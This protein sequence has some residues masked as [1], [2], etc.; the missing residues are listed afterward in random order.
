MKI[1]SSL[2]LICFLT[3]GVFAQQDATVFGRVTY[4]GEPVVEGRV[5]INSKSDASLRFETTTD[6]NGN[7]RFE[8]IPTGRYSILAKR[9]ID[10]ETGGKLEVGV[11][12]FDLNSG[13]KRSINIEMSITSAFR[14]KE[15][16]DVKIA[17]GISQPID[18]VSKTV[19]IIDSQ[20]IAN[21]NEFSFADALRT[22]PGLRVQQLGGFG[23]TA[24]IKTRGL[25]NQDTA[26]LIDGVRFRDA[27]SITG[28]A[29]AFLSDFVFTN[30]DR[31]EVLRGSGS[32]LYGTNAIG[33]V[34]DF[35]TERPRD[36][37]HG[38]FLGEGGNL[39]LKRILG[40]V[41]DGFDNFGFSLGVSRTVYSEG[42]DG[43]DDA[44][45]TNATGRIDFRPTDKTNISG[46]VYFS[47]AFVR[48]NS[49]PDTI[50]T[51]PATNATIIDAN[52]LSISELNRYADGTPVS[53][54]DAVNANFIPD[55][56]D[57][58]AI[59]K[60]SFF[61]GQIS[62]I[63]SITPTLSLNATYQG[64]KTSRENE[65]DGLGV[66]F[67]PFGGR[68]TSFFDGQIHTLNTHFDWI[69]NANNLVTVGYEYE[70]VKFGND[71]LTADST[72]DFST[73]AKQQS[74]TFYVQD[75]LSF[76]GDRLKVAGGFRTQWFSLSS[77]VFGVNN[78]PYNNLVLEN[79]PTAYTFD[80]AASY[81]F[82]STGTKIRGHVGNGYRVPSLYERLGTFYSSFS[83]NF[84]ALGDP[85]LEPESSI[86]FDFGVDQTAFDKR[87][88]FSATYFYTKLIDTIGFGN[89]VP[90]IGDTS[91]PFGGYLNQDGGISRG[92]EFSGEI[93]ATDSTNIFASY[94]YTNSDQRSPQ[95]SGS[96]SFES[97]GIPKHQFTFVATQRIKN[98]TLNFDFLATSDYLAPI[99]SNQ[100]FTTYVYRFD[101]NRRA[102][103]TG[104]YIIPLNSE[105]LRFRIFGTV[106]NIFDYDYFENGFR[107]EGRTARG[108]LGISF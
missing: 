85:N 41:S 95:V 108:G 102:D 86:A 83:Q 30:T 92:G 44:N 42:I 48:L 80:G 7:Y 91:R 10:I 77:P 6:A 98:L 38:S 25:R 60:S 13:E 11:S 88:R 65:N 24:N 94:T 89:V 57:P 93:R 61:N 8:N 35:R 68:Q 2:L 43:E 46:R 78:A 22:V 34:L 23:K 63:H 106:G 76:F 101:G 28:D 32:S 87:A 17:S 5:V 56:N 96:G 33:G 90:D 69:A 45:N 49:N 19:N 62:L 27:A 107:T 50:G 47:D 72:G 54:F 99:F 104:S 59:Q 16:V 74:N 29:S 55:T 67:Q 70:W 18:E 36:G 26:I 73:R 15:E 21:R 75:L 51:L 12:A 20:E 40:N 84:I 39:G 66:G 9:K 97:L 81:Y 14:I 103:L 37:F 82:R 64:L 71:G 1:S 100:T 53:E 4:F 58:D 31:V 79:P 105:N 52:P 3:I